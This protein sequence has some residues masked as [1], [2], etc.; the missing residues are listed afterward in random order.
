MFYTEDGITGTDCTL[1][2]FYPIRITPSTS[3]LLHPTTVLLLLLPTGTTATGTATATTTS[4]P[5]WPR[6]R[7]TLTEASRGRP[8]ARA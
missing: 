6:G 4:C 5:A 8:S 2:I 7:G 3:R 1:G